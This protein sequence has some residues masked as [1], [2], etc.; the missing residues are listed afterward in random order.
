M[1]WLRRLYRWWVGE[2]TD[3]SHEPTQEYTD[4]LEEGPR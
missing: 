2:P 3:W 4:W 1:R